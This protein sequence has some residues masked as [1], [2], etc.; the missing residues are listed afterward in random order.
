MS[1]EKRVY[2]A[3]AHYS[4]GNVIRRHFLTKRA[5]DKWAKNRR[6]GY[7]S[8]N[9]ALGLHP[10]DS[11]ALPTEA[12]PSIPPADRV[13]IAD[14]DPITFPTDNTSEHRPKFRDGMGH[15]PDPDEFKREADRMAAALNP[16]ETKTP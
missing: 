12:A 14:S 16:E 9:D 4:D 1:R 11:G 2:R 10:F 5:R 15:R 8:F 6:K 3:V 13:D 7:P